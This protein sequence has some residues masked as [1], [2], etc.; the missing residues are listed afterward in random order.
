MKCASHTASNIVEHFW[1][2]IQG[3]VQ[4]PNRSL[5]S[6]HPLF[7]YTT[8]HGCDNWCGGRSTSRSVGLHLKICLHRRDQ[9]L[10][11]CRQRWDHVLQSANRLHWHQETLVQRGCISHRWKRGCQR[12][13]VWWC[14][15]DQRIGRCSKDMVGCNFRRM[16]KAHLVDILAQAITM[17]CVRFQVR[18]ERWKGLVAVDDA[19]VWKLLFRKSLIFNIL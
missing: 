8:Y 19:S 15:L 12:Q 13:E 18:T 6:I 4:K 7:I 11:H 16:W 9:K 5:P 17:R 10:F 1:I 2:S 14:L 3:R